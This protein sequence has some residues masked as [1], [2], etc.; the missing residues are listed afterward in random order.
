MARNV[1]GTWVGVLL[2]A[3]CGGSQLSARAPGAAP[4]ELGGPCS[5]DAQ[6]DAGLFCE[7]GDPGGQCLKKCSKSEECGAGGRCVDEKKCYRRCETTADCGRPGYVCGGPAP[8][9]FCDAAGEG[10]EDE[11]REERR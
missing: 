4:S 7:K 5:A 1:T 2:L 9:K 8:N 11:E 10:D 6:C 3:A